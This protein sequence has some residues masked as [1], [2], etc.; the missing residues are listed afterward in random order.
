MLCSLSLTSSSFNYCCLT[1]SKVRISD[2]GCWAL[3]LSFI[4][5]QLPLSTASVNSASCL[6][7][8]EAQRGAF[9][10]TLFVLVL[11]KF[12]AR[13]PAYAPYHDLSGVVVREATL[14]AAPKPLRRD[15]CAMPS[16]TRRSPSSF[17]FLLPSHVLL[18]LPH[19]AHTRAH[20]LSPQLS[21]KRLL[22]L[23][24]YTDRIDSALPKSHCF[25]QRPHRCIEMDQGSASGRSY[26]RS[27]CSAA[28]EQHQALL[29]LSL[30]VV[31]CGRRS[32]Q[33]GQQMWG[34]TGGAPFKAR[35]GDAGGCL[36]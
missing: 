8:P 18:S 29:W 2:H 33:R 17:P 28:C 26:E 24:A 23:W 14:V 9:L 32:R 3:S 11:S 34:R 10:A 1:R 20:S 16:S 31:H 25:S 21:S 6:L 4:T 12:F 5:S 27:H 13:D 36:K 35:R 19:H 30:G 22:T 15:P 7:G